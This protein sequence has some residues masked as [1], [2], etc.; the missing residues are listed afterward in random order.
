MN[1]TNGVWATEYMRGPIM[2]SMPFG[3]ADEILSTLDFATAGQ[4]VGMYMDLLG[5]AWSQ[6]LPNGEASRNPL[7]KL[8][9]TS[10]GLMAPLVNRVFATRPC[11][12]AIPPGPAAQPPR[13]L[14]AK[15]S[16][17]RIA[18]GNQEAELRRSGSEE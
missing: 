11:D 18:S 14:P 12:D 9:A 1:F 15:R 8:A 7:R 10:L 17:P 3:L 5:K 6:P 2:L 4:T 13:I 16:R